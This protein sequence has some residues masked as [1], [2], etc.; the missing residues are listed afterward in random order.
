[1]P[2]LMI[3]GLNDGDGDRAR[4]LRLWHF[5]GDE[6]QDWKAS[7]FPEIIQPALSDTQGSTALFTYTPK[8]KVNHTYEAYQ[9]ALVADPRVWQAFKYKSVENPHLKPEDIELLS[10]NP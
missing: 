1:M 6:W 2:D 3:M 9:N 4:G 5:G 10:F 8:G 7:I